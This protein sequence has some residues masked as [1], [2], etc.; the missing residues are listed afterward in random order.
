MMQFVQTDPRMMDVFKEITGI[1][2]M[3]MQAQQMKGKEKSEDM[4]KKRD[5]E[6]AK[7]K[8]E[9]EK[10]RKEDEENALPEEEKSR[11]AR[12]KQAEVKKNEGNEF[13][14]KKQF[15]QALQLYDEAISFDE[16]EVTYYNNKAAV[17]FE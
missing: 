15:E 1:D 10:K 14:K 3:D 8:A 16:T 17:Y 7:R 5:E 4:R 13:Y 12:K 6:D 2:L 9:E 11:I